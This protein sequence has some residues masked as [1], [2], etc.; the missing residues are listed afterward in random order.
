MVLST[1]RSRHELATKVAGA[2]F[3]VF[4]LVLQPIVALNVPAAFATTGTVVINEFNANNEPNDWVELYNPTPGD[5]TLTGWYLRDNTEGNSNKLLLSGTLAA[6][7][8]ASFEYANKLNTG[9]DAV[10]LFDASNTLVDS[11]TYGGAGFIATPGVGQYAARATDG[12]AAWEIRSVAS[13]TATNNAAPTPP[14]APVLPLADTTKPSGEVASS[15]AVMNNSGTI[16]VSGHDDSGIKKI[17]FVTEG[18]GSGQP[19]K[20]WNVAGAPVSEEVSVNLASLTNGTYA[21]GTH[22]IKASIEDMAGNIKVLPLLSFRVDNTR[23]VIEV[24]SSSV[25]DVDAKQF[26]DVSFKLKDNYQ[27]DK[28]ILNAGEAHEWVRDFTNNAY[29]DA[30]FGNIKSHLV[31]GTNTITL[32]DVAGNSTVYE[33]TYDTVAPSVP[34]LLSPVDG[35]IVNASTPV[36]NDWEF[37]GD[38]VHH[39]IY[40]SYNLNEDG[41]CNYGTSLDEFVGTDSQ[42]AARTMD[43][44]MKFCWRVRVIDAAMNVGEWSDAWFMTVDN[45]YV[46][47]V[48]PEEPTEP[49]PETPGEEEPTLP[50][51]EVDDNEVEV[52]NE[53]DNVAPERLPSLRLPIANPT[54]TTSGTTLTVVSQQTD[55]DTPEVLSATDKAD[56]KKSA[57]LE[58]TADVLGA[59]TTSNGLFGIAWY[60]WLAGIAVIVALWWM[61]TGMRRRGNEA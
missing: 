53:S 3:A 61:V 50:A 58:D 57:P 52:T 6:G 19:Y 2:L 8:W 17:S 45:S 32:Y 60:W 14:P 59:N 43:D 22:T 7:S 42:T 49:T 15:A 1:R 46:P 26:S 4:A 27:A 9:N 48:E 35:A 29:S 10:R 20:V 37:S 56:S 34:T 21:N 33:F 5:V 47:P 31:Q 54:A 38:S 13:K 18:E 39:Y 51:E 41:T 28:Y 12:A 40:E 23:P 24:K 16:T 30:N 55:T 11:I 44:G 25:G 36:A